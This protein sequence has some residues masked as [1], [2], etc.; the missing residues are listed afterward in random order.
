MQ[1]SSADA[2]Q[3]QLQLRLI[4]AFS[5]LFLLKDFGISVFDPQT[6]PPPA[7]EEVAIP[8]I[9]HP[10]T[11]TCLHCVLPS[12]GVGGDGEVR[13]GRSERRSEGREKRGERERE[14]REG[15]SG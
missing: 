8:L 1:H 5:H 9:R 6:N 3:L 14:G 7:A 13:R 11:Q 12:C 15:V 2:K 10:V 4:S